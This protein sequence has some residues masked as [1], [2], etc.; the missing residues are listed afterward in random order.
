VNVGHPGPDAWRP[1]S[2]RLDYEDVVRTL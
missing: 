1:R 2:P